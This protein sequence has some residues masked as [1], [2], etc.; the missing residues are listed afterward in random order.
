MALC[1][2]FC[3]NVPLS[4]Y[5][6]THSQEILNNHMNTAHR[7]SFLYARTVG[8]P[9]KT[10]NDFIQQEAEIGIDQAVALSMSR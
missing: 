2:L 6:L 3:A 1:G 5:S 9:C 8:L 7:I 4:N 10:S